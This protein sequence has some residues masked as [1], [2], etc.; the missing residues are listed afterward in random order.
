MSDKSKTAPT[1]SGNCKSADVKECL[2]IHLALNELRDA[3]QTDLDDT[4]YKD[5]SCA[6][7]NI[8]MN[9]VV[10]WLHDNVEKVKLIDNK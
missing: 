8:T 5:M 7:T 1:C 6:I 3:I 9:S 4:G 10:D 2:D